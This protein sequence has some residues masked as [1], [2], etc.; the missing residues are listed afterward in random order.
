VRRVGGSDTLRRA[1]RVLAIEAAAV[2]ALAGR[3]DDGFER[4]VA[5]LAQCAGK[6]VVT[7]MG[8]SG[9]IC[10]KIAATMT[11]TGTPAVFLHAAEAAHGDAGVFVKGD[12]VVALSGSGETEEIVRLLPLVKRLDLPLVALTGDLHSTLARAADVVLDVSVTEEA[13]PMGLAP[14]ASTTA[15][16]ALGDALAVVLFERKRFRAEDFAVLHPGGALG[17]RFL[18]VA[19]VM[20]GGETMPLVHLT[21]PFRDTLVEITS[22]RL[23]VTGVLDAAGNLAGIITD[24]DLRRALERSADVRTSTAADIMTRHPKVITAGA[25]AERALALMERHSI[26]SLFIL[27]ESGRRPVGVVHLHDLLKAGV[28]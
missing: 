25:L 12:A 14:T 19:D 22:K 4:A 1:R 20:H 21:T 13:C 26:T 9:H 3:L 27:E 11:S 2:K 23:G 8:K 18:K 17:R 5:I 24:G 6:V 7:G 16:L 15:A 28:V 10:R